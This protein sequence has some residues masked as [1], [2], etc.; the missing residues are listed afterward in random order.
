MIEIDCATI[1]I[2]ED[3]TRDQKTRFVSSDLDQLSLSGLWC[4]FADCTAITLERFKG[5]RGATEETAQVTD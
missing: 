3:V 2:R 4:R 5:E 1:K